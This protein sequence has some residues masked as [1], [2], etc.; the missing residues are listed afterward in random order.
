MRYNNFCYYIFDYCHKKRYCVGN[1]K[2]CIYRGYGLRYSRRKKR[3]IPEFTS[4]VLGHSFETI[5]VGTQSQYFWCAFCG[6]RAKYFILIERE[7]GRRFKVGRT[8]L[9]KIGLSIRRNAFPRT[10]NKQ[11]PKEEKRG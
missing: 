3:W 2:V 6:S 8:C 10:K 5:E 4:I 1:E 9:E 11:P 7:D